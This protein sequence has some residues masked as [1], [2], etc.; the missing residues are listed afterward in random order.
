V[1][2]KKGKQPIARVRPGYEWLWVHAF[3]CPQT[4]ESFCALLPK[5]NAEAVNQAL[6][7]FA[8]Q[9]NPDGKKQIMLLLDQA[10]QH[11]SKK[12]QIPGW[13]EFYFLPP[14][15]PEL[16]PCEEMWKFIDEVVANQE[17]RGIEEVRPVVV[18]RCAWLRQ[19]RERVRR[20]ILFAWWPLVRLP[21]S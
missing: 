21:S 5:V 12:L 16:Q 10:G 8:E 2:S 19:Q 7:E 14:K 1:W 13:L 11:K 9:V 6:K 3:C 18:R 4:G 17:W 20:E 15:S